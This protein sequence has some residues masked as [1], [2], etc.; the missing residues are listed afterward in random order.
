[1]ETADGSRRS[2]T[3]STTRLMWWIVVLFFVFGAP[4]QNRV[5]DRK[6][7]ILWAFCS[8]SSCV[9]T[10]YWIR[11]GLTETGGG[12]WERKT[13]PWQ[14]KRKSL[15]TCSKTQCTVLKTV[16]GGIFLEWAKSRLQ[17]IWDRE[18]KAPGSGGNGG[19]GGV[20]WKTACYWQDPN[21][22][23]RP[24]NCLNISAVF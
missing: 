19:W 16:K 12:G 4:V 13:E 24:K 6:S 14:E 21:Q 9:V 15:S 18:M 3:Q 10:F 17:G 22:A 8:C 23:R 2:V 1:M 11:T 5:L 7:D 20:T